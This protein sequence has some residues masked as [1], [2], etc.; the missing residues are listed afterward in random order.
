M[1]VIGERNRAV[2]RGAAARSE[3]W[4]E[5][6]FRARNDPSKNDSQQRSGCRSPLRDR[7]DIN[8]VRDRG[9]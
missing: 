6:T 9:G 7:D 2:P 8:V 4:G 1:A 5:I 3:A